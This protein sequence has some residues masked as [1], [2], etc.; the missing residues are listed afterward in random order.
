MLIH[1]AVGMFPVPH[2]AQ[3]LKAAH[4][5]L[6]KVL[7][8]LGT[9]LP[10]LGHGHIL[11]QL[12]LG[13]LD[14]PLNGQ[15]VVVPAGDIGG[16]VTHHGMAA[17]DEIFQRLIQ[18]MAHVDI[19]IGEGRAVMQNK[20]GKIFVLLQHFVVQVQVLP[21]LQ[22]SRLPCRQTGLHREVGLRGDDRIFVVHWNNL[23]R[24]FY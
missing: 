16:V 14:G 1:G 4:L 2:H 3:T 19:A 18:R 11:V 20:A 15:T 21:V 13:S 12:L 24:L 7:S 8:K 5:L 9:G 10:E 6:N 22:H 23:R 17:D